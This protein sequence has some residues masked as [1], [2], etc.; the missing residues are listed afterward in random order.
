VTV[1]STLPDEQPS[2]EKEAI[3]LMPPEKYLLFD[4]EGNSNSIRSPRKDGVFH[5]RGRKGKGSTREKKGVD[6]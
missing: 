5:T 4:R 6:L 1:S 2:G 3:L